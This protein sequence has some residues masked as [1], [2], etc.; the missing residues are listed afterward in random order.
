M[1]EQVTIRNLNADT[2]A[3]YA[4]SP[5]YSVSSHLQG[6]SGVLAKLIIFSVSLGV[7]PLGSY[8]LSLKYLWNG[9]FEAHFFRNYVVHRSLL[10]TE[11]STFAAITAVVAANIVLVAYIISAVLEDK[12][13]SVAQK[14]Q[15][16]SKKNK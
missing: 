1:S 8:F 13:N 14:Q 10:C 12:Q 11:N 5:K 4:F 2:A 7:L 3:R 9:K 6:S 15:A 16:E